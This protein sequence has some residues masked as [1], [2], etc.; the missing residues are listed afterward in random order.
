MKLLV[1]LIYISVTFCFIFL[2]SSSGR[3]PHGEA[4]IQLSYSLYGCS[5]KWGELSKLP[6]EVFESEL[7]KAVQEVFPEMVVPEPLDV[8]FKYW[9]NTCW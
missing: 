3:G 8:V 5:V 2:N 4:V 1:R 6:K 7:K 9:D